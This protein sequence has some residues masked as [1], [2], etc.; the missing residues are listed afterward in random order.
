[1]DGSDLRLAEQVS[2]G[3]DGVR[4]RGSSAR[5][6]RRLVIDRLS[7]A[8]SEERRWTAVA[9]RMDLLTSWSAPGLLPIELWQP[10][11]DDPFCVVP[12]R[13]STLADAL[14]AGRLGEPSHVRLVLHQLADVLHEAQRLGLWHGALAPSRILLGETHVELDLRDLRMGPERDDDPVDAPCRAPEGP[15]PEA[16]VYALGALARLLA[17]SCGPLPELEELVA[18][19]LARDPA[20]RPLLGELRERRRG[21]RVPAATREPT[22]ARLDRIGH[23]ALGALLGE[24]GMGR[25][26]RGRDATGGDEVAVKVLH[27]HAADDA[28]ALRRFYR[29]ARV[30]AGLDSPH[31]ARFVEAAEDQ[32]VHYLAMELVEGPSLREVLAKRG[33]LPPGEALDVVRDVALALADVHDLGVVHRD[34]KPSNMLLAAPEGGPDHPGARAAARPLTKLCDFGIAC[35]AAPTTTGAGDAALTVAG[36]VVGSAGYMAPEQCLGAPLDA[37][38]DIYGLGMS[39]FELLVGRRAFDDPELV[40]ILRKHLEAPLPDLRVLR[41]EAGDGV[42]ALV[43]RMTAKAPA[44]RFADARALL[45][46]IERLRRGDASGIA[47]HP[48]LPDAVPGKLLA[49]RFAWQLAATARELW[50]Y[51]SDTERFNRA[52]GIGAVDFSRERDDGV[53]QTRGS[54]REKG[55][56]LAWREH[57]FEWV[58]PRRLG[59]LREFGAGPF[60]WLRSVVQLE[61]CGEGTNLVHT[62]EV[63]PRGVLGRAAAA[64]E[65]GFKLRR[66]FE[67]VYQ[68]IDRHA[69]RAR[70]ERATGASSTE[71]MAALHGAY[72]PPPRPSATQEARLARAERRLLDLGVDSAACHALCDHLRHGSAQDVAR[73]RPRVLAARSGVD[74]RALVAACLHGAREG[75]LDMLWDIVCPRC[76]IPSSIADS[77]QRVHDHGRCDACD[78]DFDNDLGRSV[79]LVFRAHAE[80]RDTE[81]RT[82]CIGGPGHTPHVLAQVRL[83]PGERFELALELEE[84]S[85]VVAGRQLARSWQLAVRR[86]APLTTWE[87][88]LRRGLPAAA[89]RT[90][91]AGRQRLVLCN[92]FDCELVVRVERKASREG[93]L[94]AADAACDPLFR[95]L[96]PGEILAPGQLV[97]VGRVTLLLAELDAAWRDADEGAVFARLTALHQRVAAAAARDGGTVVKIQGDGILASF[98]DA[99]A[100]ARSAFFLR[101]DGVRVAATAGPALAT[102]LN[103]RL[104]YFGKLLHRLAALVAGTPPGWALLGEPL[105]ADPG[106]I[107]WLAPLDCTRRVVTLGDVVGLALGADAPGAGRRPPDAPIG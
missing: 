36:T 73:I 46:E 77:L 71:V 8:R 94:T 82:Y 9:R 18:R 57:P 81:I 99:V 62:V 14:H 80:V 58:A 103:G 28:A 86:G 102:T 70:A 26:Y 64:M 31:I 12:E 15:G 17:E 10:H 52:V 50:P 74:A 106:V 91:G 75:L 48:R 11:G 53:V 45:E 105:V 23:F 92:D 100:A 38:A 5:D 34:V 1:M 63:E 88:S 56:T 7:Q 3:A 104:D 89:P 54:M 79:E 84:G 39:L 40:G 30:L 22:P 41:P 6:E 19:M 69:L 96:F 66:G 13:A 51:V 47:A 65:I 60:V 68:R 97:A 42:A 2:S 20:A 101:D 49:Y 93:A 32:G 107:E 98:S 61:P 85:Y 72:E 83:A 43:E 29:E 67:R 59:V 16:D 21:E 90:L 76:Q 37:R 24:G 78:I 4:Y 33:P 25:V 27:P 44:E 55:I 87:L 35:E 95:Q